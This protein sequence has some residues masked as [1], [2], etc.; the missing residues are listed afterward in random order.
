MLEIIH[1]S[2]NRISHE[3][4]GKNPEVPEIKSE[5]SLFGIFNQEQT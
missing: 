5:Q 4:R 3:F 2:K 1:L